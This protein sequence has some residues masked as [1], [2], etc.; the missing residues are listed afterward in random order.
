MLFRANTNSP[1]ECSQLGWE[2]MAPINDQSL[3]SSPK[4]VNIANIIAIEE[5]RSGR[6]VAA[7]PATVFTFVLPFVDL[8]PGHE[9]ARKVVP[10]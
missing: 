5:N 1:I 8:R 3:F 4:S 10:D 2:L 7:M 6:A 9:L